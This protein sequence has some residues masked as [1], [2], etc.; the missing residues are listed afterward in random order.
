MAVGATVAEAADP[1]VRG[2]CLQRH[3]LH[4]KVCGPAID[5]QVRVLLPQVLIGCALVVH[6][7]H[8]ALAEGRHASTALQVPKVCLGA[9]DQA[10]VV[11]LVQDLAH[12]AHLNGISQGRP[13]PVGLVDIDLWRLQLRLRE[14]RAEKALLRRTVRGREA[15]AAAVGIGVAPSQHAVGGGLAVDGIGALLDD[16][17]GAP[18]PAAVAVCGAVEGEAAAGKREHVAGAVAGPSAW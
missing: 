6:H 2:V 3:G 11:A 8:Y 13:S 15:R 14:N 1:H 9:R 18:L 12:G 5:V 16:H 4:D 17:G 7:G 10:W